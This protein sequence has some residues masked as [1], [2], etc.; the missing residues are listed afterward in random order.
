MSNL[1]NEKGQGLIEYI[2]IV[3]LMGVLAIAAVNALGRQTQSGYRGA[4]RQL[5][6]EFAKFGG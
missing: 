6:S 2:L 4:T 3:G 5:A 1:R